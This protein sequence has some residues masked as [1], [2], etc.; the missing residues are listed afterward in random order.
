MF[1]TETRALMA[2]GYSLISINA[3]AVIFP[4]IGVDGLVYVSGILAKLV[5]LDTEL[6]TNIRDSMAT[7]VGDLGLSYGAY[8]SQA[9]QQGSR[10]LK[11]LAAATGTPVVFYRYLGSSGTI[12]ARNY[13]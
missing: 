10:L 13:Y 1:T 8:I 3:K 12:I 2:L 7:K 6:E 4:Q 11:E 9:K 5:V